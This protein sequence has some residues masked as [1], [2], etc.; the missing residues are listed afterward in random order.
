MLS[1]SQRFKSCGYWF[2]SVV[3]FTRVFCDVLLVLF[4]GLVIICTHEKIEVLVDHRECIL[5][6]AKECSRE[7]LLV[8]HICL[9]AKG[10]FRM[11]IG[12]C[13]RGSWITFQGFNIKDQECC[14]WVK[15]QE[16]QMDIVSHKVDQQEVHSRN[17]NNSLVEQLVL[18][19]VKYVQRCLSLGCNR[20]TQHIRVRKAVEATYLSEITSV[21]SRINRALVMVKCG[22]SVNSMLEESI[23]LE[24]VMDQV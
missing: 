13:F 11:E 3:A 24:V 15:K 5:S 2:A 23:E 9:K 12:V 22:S 8:A 1:R 6:L 14:R 7:E 17:T 18:H 20:F 4:L 10:R 21:L 19:G 16:H